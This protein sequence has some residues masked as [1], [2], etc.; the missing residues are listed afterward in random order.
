MS[1]ALERPSPVLSTITNK[2][3]AN[4][5]DR[6]YQLISDRNLVL[7][8]SARKRICHHIKTR[9]YQRSGFREQLGSAG[10]GTEL[11]LRSEFFNLIQTPP[12][13]NPVANFKALAFG[14]VNGAY[15]VRRLQLNATLEFSS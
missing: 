10:T 4:K 15:E 14:T 2:A 8:L 12:F 1:A 5:Q 7:T 3:I 6:Q 13:N 11:P 9:H